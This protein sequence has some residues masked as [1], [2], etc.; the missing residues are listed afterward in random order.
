MG[1]VK[2]GVRCRPPFQDEVPHGAF[3]SVVDCLPTDKKVT[4]TLEGV[5]DQFD[6]SAIYPYISRGN[7]EISF[8]TISL[9][10]R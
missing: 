7:A 1:R 9:A 2:V 6:T 10:L 5:R 3:S 4:I 8:S